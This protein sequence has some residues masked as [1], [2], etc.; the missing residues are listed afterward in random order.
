MCA[1]STRASYEA[2]L[3]RVVDY[4][5]DH[6]EEELRFDKLSEIAC[7]SPYHW[8]RIYTSMRGETI[9][10]TVRRLRLAR[11]ADR[12][13][14]SE[15]AIASIADRAGYGSVE[16]FGRAFKEAYGA[17]PAAYRDK[18][19]HAIFKEATKKQRASQFVVVMELLSPTR[20]AVLTHEGS[21]MQ[22]DQAMNRLFAELGRQQI[23]PSEPRMIAEFFDD[24]DLVAVEA[25]RSRACAPI[26]ETVALASPLE[27]AVLRGGLYARLR[28]Q[29]PYADMKEA[30]R[31]L[32]GVWLP[33]SD[34]EAD[35][36]PVFE[37]YL[38]NPRDVRPTELLTD[39]H[40]PLVSP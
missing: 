30:Y 32:F 9:F 24:P 16:A 26:D 23:S 11:A 33:S 40:V 35:D 7:L 15:L 10:A 39:I 38:N 6:L 5:Y 17:G 36:A 13:A 12:L 14:N 8:H 22:I 34:H 28:Y 37:A 2:R 4:I 27:S 19:S 29:G 18:G 25:L 21:Y 1:A 3:A 31:W 20:C